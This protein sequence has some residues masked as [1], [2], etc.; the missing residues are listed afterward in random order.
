M[1]FPGFDRADFDLFSIPDFPG[2]MGE[3]R[4]RLRPKLILLGADLA[5]LLTEAVDGTLVP[6]VAQHMRRRVNP[7]EETWAAFCRDRKGYKRWTHY[8]VAVSASRVRVTV[9]VEDDADDKPHFG[10]SLEKRA[11]R[12][13]RAL[14]GR[15]SPVH[16]Y[17]AAEPSARQ[18]TA[19]R[20]TELGRSLQ[21][22]KTAKFQA[23]IEIPASE[24]EQLSPADFE[25]WVIEQA[26]VLKPLYLAGL[27]PGPA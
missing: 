18:M 3:I 12:L 26:K 8:R 6:H 15:K 7:P 9:F 16:W 11:A 23:G 25:S 5:P 4:S 21:R 13:L 17:T 27:G 19:D 22:L 24:A 20:L 10:A 14:G 2:R 1:D